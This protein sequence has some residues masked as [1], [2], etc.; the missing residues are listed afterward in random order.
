MSKAGSNATRL[1]EKRSQ[2]GV[3]DKSS[4][5]I[6]EQALGKFENEDAAALLQDPDEWLMRGNQGQ[7]Q[8][9]VT[10]REFLGLVQTTVF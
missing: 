1:C 6:F 2:A 7:P 10:Y 8:T 3:L 9:L 4:T 5:S